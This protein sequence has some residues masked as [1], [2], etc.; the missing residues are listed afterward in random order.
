[1]GGD[2]AFRRLLLDTVSTAIS[3]PPSSSSLIELL[4]I[5]TP[6]LLASSTDA[7]QR[8]IAE[9]NVRSVS[10]REKLFR[11][12]QLRIH[13]D[14]HDEDGRAMELFQEVKL[15]YERCIKVRHRKDEAEWQRRHFGGRLGATKSSLQ[16]GAEFPC[17]LAT[18]EDQKTSLSED[19]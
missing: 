18:F 9:E 14:K 1:M 16:H 2:S 19:L 12:L 3:Q 4:R 8:K 17:L 11:A 15:F 13:P 10:K 7:R 6:G 5:A